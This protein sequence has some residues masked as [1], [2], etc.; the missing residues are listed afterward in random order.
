MVPWKA[1]RLP[2]CIATEILWNR[3][4][5]SR[6]SPVALDIF[7]A[8]AEMKLAPSSLGPSVSSATGMKMKWC[9]SEICRDFLRFLFAAVSATAPAPRFESG[10]YEGPKCH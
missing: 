3:K 9:D 2:R 6:W 8:I 7:S 1:V 5:F 10:R 4:V